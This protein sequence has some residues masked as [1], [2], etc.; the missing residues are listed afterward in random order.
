MRAPTLL[1]G[2]PSEA[3][4]AGLVN[5]VKL[6]PASGNPWYLPSSM[7]WRKCLMMFGGMKKPAFSRPG[8]PWKE[9]PT[10]LSS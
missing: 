5:L 6:M 3:R 4:K 10:T 9:T 8:F 1:L 7:S 2:R